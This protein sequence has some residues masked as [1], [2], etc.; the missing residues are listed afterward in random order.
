[1]Q[2]VTHPLFL[3]P[4]HVSF[5]HERLNLYQR[6]VLQRLAQVGNLHVQGQGVGIGS[7]SPHGFEQAVA[8]DSLIDI[9]GQQAEDV[10]LPRSDEHLAAGRAELVGIVT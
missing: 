10:S 8:R 3:S 7:R 2:C 6:V 5:F 4:Q 9:Q 1:M